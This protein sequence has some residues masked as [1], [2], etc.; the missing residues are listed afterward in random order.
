M[1]QLS[2][3]TLRK[4]CISEWKRKTAKITKKSFIKRVKRELKVFLEDSRVRQTIVQMGQSGLSK[5]EIRE[6]VINSFCEA[7]FLEVYLNEYFPDRN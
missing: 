4:I 5:H 7:F 6:R 2:A 3:K 1:V